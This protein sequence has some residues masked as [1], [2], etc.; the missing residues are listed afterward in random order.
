MQENLLEPHPAGSW[1]AKLERLQLRV[2][3]CLI[4]QPDVA[5]P[6]FLFS[7]ISVSVRI[8]LERLFT[9][10]KLQIQLTDS[11]SSCHAVRERDIFF[12]SFLLPSQLC[13]PISLLSHLSL[14]LSTSLCF[15]SAHHL[16]FFSSFLSHA[17]G[18]T[19]RKS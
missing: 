19:S 2:H 12:T 15:S 11:A 4:V 3:R 1:S 5:L 7:M 13:P 10:F 17:S 9:S 6:L 16:F 14:I 18:P 8:I